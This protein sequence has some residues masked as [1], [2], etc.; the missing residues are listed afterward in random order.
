MVNYHQL[1]LPGCRFTY[2]QITVFAASITSHFFDKI[3]LQFRVENYRNFIMFS[4]ILS[5]FVT[6]F[7]V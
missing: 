7:V 2:K 3:C 1:M 6:S 5:P 4:F